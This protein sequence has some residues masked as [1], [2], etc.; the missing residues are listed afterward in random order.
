MRYNDLMNASSTNTRFGG[1]T[2]PHRVH[3]NAGGSMSETSGG[4]INESIQVVNS[5]P[6]AKP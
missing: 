6:L 3:Q 1:D 4:S 2:V 5:A